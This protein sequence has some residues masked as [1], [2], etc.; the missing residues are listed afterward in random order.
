M[1]WYRDQNKTNDGEDSGSE[2]DGDALTAS[3]KGAL[4]DGSHKRILLAM[5]LLVDSRILLENGNVLDGPAWADAERILQTV[6]ENS[7]L[8]LYN[9]FAKHLGDG[10]TE[11]DDL[12]RD[13]AKIL[14]QLRDA[15]GTH[16]G[17]A[18]LLP[19]TSLPTD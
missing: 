13:E 18:A 8:R 6:L 12:P 19:R 16:S 9:D 4:T 14:A 2:S 10:Y 7:R 11:R 3:L 17:I 5:A 1:W 15:I